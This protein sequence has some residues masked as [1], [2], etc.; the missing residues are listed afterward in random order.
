MTLHQRGFARAVDADDAD[1][2]AGQEGEAD[3]LQDLL[4]AGIG[5]GEL[6]QRIDILGRGHGI[7][8][9]R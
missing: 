4:A 5:F 3:V 6:L 9:K 2:G 1:L 8:S 7:P